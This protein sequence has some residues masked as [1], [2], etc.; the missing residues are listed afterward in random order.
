MKQKEITKIIWRAGFIKDKNAIRQKAK[1]DMRNLIACG[2]I[3]EL[4]RIKGFNEKE[5]LADCGLN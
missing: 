5:F 1:E 3:G 2:F 4:K